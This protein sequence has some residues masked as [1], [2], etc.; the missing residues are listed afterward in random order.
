M[1]RGILLREG[2]KTIDNRNWKIRKKEKII[3]SLFWDMKEIWK[4]KK[5][6]D[7]YKSCYFLEK[8]TLS[9]KLLEFIFFSLPNVYLFIMLLISRLVQANIISFFVQSAQFSNLIE[10]VEKNMMYIHV[11]TL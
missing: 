1:M 7:K 8:K 11:G 3:S 10:E 5:N 9:V 2:K 6:D 4:R